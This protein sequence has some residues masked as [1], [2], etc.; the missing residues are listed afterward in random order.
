MK[1]IVLGLAVL[2][3]AG[4]GP[5]KT[6]RIATKQAEIAVAMQQME[7]EQEQ[8][9]LAE[10]KFKASGSSDVTLQNPG[11]KAVH[12]GIKMKT[13]A[14]RRLDELRAEEILLGK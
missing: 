13:L 10:S 11:W 6:E 1:A 3:L 4:C 5:S 8:L 12:D 2:A 7:F 9:E 14:K